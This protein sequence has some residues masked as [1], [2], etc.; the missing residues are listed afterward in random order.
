M[1]DI[2]E[3]IKD[4]EFLE[5]WEDKYQLLIDMGRSLPKMDETL[6]IDGNKL[7]GCQ[8]TV[9][10]ISRENGDKTLFFLAN[11]DAF[12]VQGLIALILKVFNN[13]TPAQIVDTD[14]SFL[15]KI[16]LD[17][18]LSITRKNGLSSLIGKIKNEANSRLEKYEK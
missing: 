5:S 14:L 18:H 7:K 11:S 4:F 3:I 10:F 13:K 2:E 17:K 15:K 9:Y 12:I 8:S 6:K 16:G 1:S